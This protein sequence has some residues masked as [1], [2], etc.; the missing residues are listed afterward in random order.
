MDTTIVE[1]IDRFNNNLAMLHQTVEMTKPVLEGMKTAMAVQWFTGNIFLILFFA[2]TIVSLV[3]YV[4]KVQKIMIGI[5][6]PVKLIAIYSI[7]FISFM[8]LFNI[9]P[10][11]GMTQ[12]QK[13][14]AGNVES[15]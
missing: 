8:V 2:M 10:Q 13:E 9:L 14:I 15:N 7:V 1:K 11:S 4:K 5:R 12:A 3:L 6:M